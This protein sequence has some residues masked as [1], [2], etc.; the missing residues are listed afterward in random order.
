MNLRI[1]VDLVH[2]SWMEIT[3][4]TLRR[5]WKKILPITPS[6]PSKKSPPAPVLA[7]LYDLAVPDDEIADNSSPP[8]PRGSYGCAMWRGLRFRI[9][10]P[11]G[12]ESTTGPSSESVPAIDDDVQVEDFQSMFRELC[13]EI[14]PSDIVS[15]LD[16]DIGN[17]GVQIYTDDEIC[18]L[19]SRST[20]DIEPE[21]GDGDDREEDEEPCPV[22]NSDAAKMFDRCLAWLEHQPEATVYNT[23][24]LRELHALAAKKR[25]QSIKQTKLDKYFAKI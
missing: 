5:S 4:D 14:E 9:S 8:E 2:E 22:T 16:S 15:W 1:V 12:Q 11:D 19:V 10:H 3:K 6:C 23:S 18:E 17:S 24:V 21:D 20:D 25:M 13:I 7:G